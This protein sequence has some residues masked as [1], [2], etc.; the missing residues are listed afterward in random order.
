MLDKL[1]NIVLANGGAEPSRQER[2][3]AKAASK[4]SAKPASDD[5]SGSEDEKP[6]KMDNAAA[7]KSVKISDLSK[8]VRS[9]DAV[10]LLV[11]ERVSTAA[12]RAQ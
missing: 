5:D 9:N 10:A 2:K 12:E 1:G 8:K 11:S 3:A 6:M 4:K 7:K